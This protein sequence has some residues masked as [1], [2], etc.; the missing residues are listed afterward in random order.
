VIYDELSEAR[1]RM[2]HRHVARALETVYAHD[3]DTVAARVA[4]HYERA[5]EL[6]EAIEYYQ[7]AAKMAQKVHCE[8]DAARYGERASALV[9]AMGADES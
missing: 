4:A 8:D 9:E 5:N 2:L 7:R 3:L 6:E 1:R